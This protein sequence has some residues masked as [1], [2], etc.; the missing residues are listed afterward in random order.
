MKN[1]FKYKIFTYKVEKVSDQT[2]NWWTCQEYPFIKTIVVD[3]DRWV[4]KKLA[5]NYFI[6]DDKV[7]DKYYDT[8]DEADRLCIFFSR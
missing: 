2:L 6:I 1:I 7:G 5:F 3:R 8:F 4:I